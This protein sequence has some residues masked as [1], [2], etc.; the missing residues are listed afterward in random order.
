MHDPA[1]DTLR[2]I[3]IKEG[4][5]I[6][7]AIFAFKEK[8]SSISTL[9][10]EI[11]IK[12]IYSDSIKRIFNEVPSANYTQNLD[13]VFSSRESNLNFDIEK[14]IDRVMKLIA[15]NPNKKIVYISAFLEQY[16]SIG[17]QDKKVIIGTLIEL[18]EK[19]LSS[20]IKDLVSLFPLS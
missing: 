10:R 18:E 2:I 8:I 19:Q 11:L 12:K 20:D 4:A 9:P 13:P 3:Q 16:T 5:E 7:K 14:E 6:K 15:L 1:L 17:E